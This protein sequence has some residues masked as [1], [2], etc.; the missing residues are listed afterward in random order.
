[1][2]NSNYALRTTAGDFILTLYEKRVDPGELPYFLGL[3]RHLA[4]RD[5]A[6]AEEA[7]IR[8]AQDYYAAQARSEGDPK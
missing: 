6:K 2:E 1:M 3:M 5:P 4:G 7:R 8:I